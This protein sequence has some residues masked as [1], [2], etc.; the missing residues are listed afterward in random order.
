[1]IYSKTFKAIFALVL[2]AFITICAIMFCMQISPAVGNDIPLADSE[3]A[4]T[5]LPTC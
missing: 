1:M 5:A 2:V 3:P 4:K